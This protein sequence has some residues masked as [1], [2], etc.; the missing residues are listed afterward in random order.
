M[1]KNL[2]FTVDFHEHGFVPG[3]DVSVN[4]LEELRAQFMAMYNLWAQGANAVL[5]KLNTI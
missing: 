1:A 3:T 5:S 4:E 2:E